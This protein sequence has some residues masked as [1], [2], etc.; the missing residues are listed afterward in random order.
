MIDSLTEKVSG[1]EG[2]IVWSRFG[3]PP[4]LT[5]KK[6]KSCGLLLIFEALIMM[7]IHVSK[8][9]IKRELNVTK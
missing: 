7:K 3:K 9:V 6:W 4:C 1:G 5:G 2:R 8:T